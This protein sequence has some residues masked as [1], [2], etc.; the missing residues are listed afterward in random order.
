MPA[1]CLT[2]SKESKKQ[3]NSIYENINKKIGSPALQIHKYLEPHIT[4]FLTKYDEKEEKIINQTIN[5]IVKKNIINTINIEGTGIF[6]KD[7]NVYNL[8]FNIAY[9]KNMQK[10]HKEVWKELGDKINIVQKNHYHPSSF[11]PHIS[12]PIRQ[13][14][15]NKTIIMDVQNE[16]LNYDFLPLKSDQLSFIHGNLEKPIVYII[17]NILYLIKNKN[18]LHLINYQLLK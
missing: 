8:H 17:K 7:T 1:I 3:L 6:R 18:C 16:L 15:N 14:I 4:L 9:D 13:K 11:I 5:K 10:I 2:F 12:I